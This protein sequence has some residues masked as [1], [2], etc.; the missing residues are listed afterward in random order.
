MKNGETKEKK[1][2]KLMSFW[3]KFLIAL[4][5]TIFA[6]CGVVVG[7]LAGQKEEFSMGGTIKYSVP[8]FTVEF[9][10]YDN[11][12]FNT[13]TVSYGQNATA[14]SSNPSKTGYT[15][16]GW[17]DYT[18]I[19][20]NRQVKSKWTVNIYTITLNNQS[21]TTAGTA[22]VYYKYGTSTFYSNSGCTTTTTSITVPTRTGYTFGGYYSA[23]NGS[24]TQYITAAGAFTSS[25]NSVV[26]VA[27]N[28]TIY[29]KWIP[30]N[31]YLR[32]DWLSVLT[33]TNSNFTAPNI[34]TI[35]FVNTIPSGTGYTTVSVGATSQTGET[36]WTA[37]TSGVLDLTAYVKAN[38]SASSKYDVIFYAPGITYAPLDSSFLFCP[39][40]IDNP[41]TDTFV[42]LTSISFGNFNTTNVTNMSGMFAY[43]AELTNLNLSSFNTSS[44]TNMLGM[45]AFCKELTTLDLSSFDMSEVTTAEM[46]LNCYDPSLEGVM[47]SK[48]RTVKT[49]SS[50]SSALFVDLPELTGYLWADSDNPSTFYTTIS[51]SNTN[52]TLIAVSNEAYLRKDWL[53]VLGSA[54]SQYTGPNIKKIYFER[55]IPTGTGYTTVSVGALNKHGT[56]AFVAGTSGVSDVTAYIK[57]NSSDSTKYDI[58]FY[59]PTTIFAPVNS[60]LLFSDPNTNFTTEFDDGV[61]LDNALSNLSNIYFDN[62]RTTYTTNMSKMFLN[63]IF[64]S[65]PSLATFDTTNVT[66]MSYMFAY[67]I[68]MSNLYFS[69]CANFKTNNVT[70]MAG[71]FLGCS[72]LSINLSTFNTSKVTNMSRMFKQCA[73]LTA[74]SNI[75]NLDTT[76]VTDMSHMF[77]GCTGA[78]GLN[79]STFNTSKV[80]NMSH[81]FSGCDK[82]TSLTL[83]SFSTGSVT[84]MS[85]MFYQ[86]SGLTSLD[87]S[88]FN[89]GNVTDMS[90]MFAMST[91]EGG[92]LNQTL[93]SNIASLNLSN[94]N[95]SKVTNMA[96]M[97]CECINL[98]SLTLSS[99]FVTNNVTDMVS[100]FAR[101]RTLTSLDLSSFDM[102]KCT[103]SYAVNDMFVGCSALTTI[104]TPKAMGSVTVDLPTP[105]NY[106]WFNS[107]LTTTY[108]TLSSSNINKTLLLKRTSYTVRFNANGG[109]VNP[110]SKTV[111]YN[112]TYGTLPTPVREGYTFKGWFT[113]ASGGT[114]ITDSTKFTLTTDQTLYAQWTISESYLQKNWLTTLS[115]AN[116]SY[117]GPN[118]K[119]IQFVNTVPSGSGYATVS[120][121]ATA[122]D[123]GT[124]WTSGSN[125]FDITAYIK[126][127]SS[128]ST[129]Y[130]IIFYSP[131]TIYAP[132][133]SSKLFGN[134][135]SSSTI[136]SQLTSLTFGNFNTSKV[137]NMAYMFY[138]CGL[139]TLD[140]TSFNTSSVNNMYYMFY[141]CT[142]LTSVNVSSFD[143]SNV[144]N[145]SYMFSNVQ[146]TSVNLSSFNTSKVT[147]MSYMFSGCSKLTSLDLSSFSMSLVTNTGNMLYGCSALTTIK[148]PKA[149]G[150]KAVDL[151]TKTAY[152]WK[153]SSGTAYTTISSSNLNTTLTWTA[154]S[155]TV[156]FN[157]N[158]GSCSTTSKQVTYD[159]TY[160]DLPT[161]TRTGYAFKG[162]FTAASGGTQ[163]TASSKVAITAAQTL[164][165][166]W[167]ANTYKVRYFD[168]F[169]NTITYTE[170]T[171]TYD[172]SSKTFP[173][174]SLTSGGWTFVSWAT[175]ATSYAATSNTAGKAVSNLTST[176]GG[177]V[178]LYSVYKRTVTLT[179]AANGGSGSTAAQ[180]EIQYYNRAGKVCNLPSVTLRAN[181]FTRTGYTFTGWQIG[182]TTYAAGA[183]VQ[184]VSDQD[185]PASVTATAQ[186]RANVYKVTLDN[187]SATS[188]GTTA[189]W[190]KFNTVE[191]GYYYYT[192][193]A[194][195]TGLANYTITVPTRTGYTFGGYYTST[196]GGGTQYINASGGCINNMYKS[197]ARN[198][199]L[200]AKWTIN[201][202]TITLNANGSSF[203]S[204][205]TLTLAAS[206]GNWNYNSIS[207]GKFAP[208]TN[209]VITIGSA[210]LTAGT[211]TKFN[212]RLYDF[213]DNK[214]IGTV[215]EGTFGQ[216]NTITITSNSSLNPD[217]DNR[218]I[219]YAG[220]TGSTANNAATFS[221]I[222]IVV[223]KTV[224]YDSTYGTL[225]T[226]TRTGYTFKGWFT[227]ASG[228]TQ[229][230]ASTTLSSAANQ[231]LYAQWTGNTYTIN[232]YNGA[233][234]LG[235]STHTYGSSKALSTWSSLGG[236][237][238]NYSFYGWTTST[239]STSRTYTDGQSVSNL[240]TTAG[241]TITLYAI[242]SGT[243]TLTYSTAR[244]TAPSKQTA[245]RYYNTK[246]GNVTSVSFTLASALSATGF[247]FGGWTISGTTYSAGASYTN[248]ANTISITATAKWNANSY[249]LTL[250]STSVTVSRTSSPYGGAST[251]TLSNG[252]TIYYGDVLKVVT[253]IGYLTIN[254]HN[255]SM[256]MDV[257]I[258]RPTSVGGSNSTLSYTNK[259]TGVTVNSSLTVYGNI[260]VDGSRNQ[261]FRSVWTGN[262]STGWIRNNSQTI[263]HSSFNTQASDMIS[264]SY[265]YRITGKCT[266]GSQSNQSASASFTET[267]YWS[268]DL[269]HASWKGSFSATIGT[270]G[271]SFH[272]SSMGAYYAKGYITEIKVWY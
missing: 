162:W 98:T 97:F 172:N 177:I 190:F 134:Y 234:K 116:S 19:T 166:Q 243:V 219:V 141:N 208:D 178:N 12:V 168:T 204:T 77:S 69:D 209:Y 138:Q 236:S 199:T 231:T 26:S 191:N 8:S 58:T 106:A 59:S 5:I 215:V 155:Y 51:S 195:T 176:N 246:G 192:N 41:L 73:K 270:D 258:S 10:D 90:H 62:F 212:I 169:N 43:C 55:T 154:N 6:T 269:T 254:G 197:E 272:G 29:A 105:D 198:F 249:K 224:T 96:Y 109:T 259:A 113:A 24:G 237:I 130:D 179:Y 265:E 102:S 84:D 117:T 40:E 257:S 50:I 144:A 261:Q 216:S 248:S 104:K 165:A 125:A 52:K 151:P 222:S 135:N 233:T 13:Q 83:S 201:T 7:V 80:T 101:C 45:F 66:D 167:T 239:S 153:N 164:Y 228:G 11:N 211:A 9:L 145:M 227:A 205:T 252:A 32:K 18:N 230:T 38:S 3:S 210:T 142:A 44:V 107:E 173:T 241:G 63:C 225:P 186:W 111:T 35:Q 56:S 21:A 185:S 4:A 251:G 119:T 174:G 202:Y 114:Q 240:T 23:E 238:S 271:V 140:L 149:I 78:T 206:T 187:Q 196:N 33:T 124:A 115:T 121:G 158:G 146:F 39:Q 223:K 34:K 244:G 46:M 213:T 247:S 133:D 30:K 28:Q 75:S 89:T 112:S 221:N 91:S 132:T 137:T 79:L 245:T 263:S 61:D 36:A 31:S 17:E 120:V 181:S 20:A 48:L 264:N 217:H 136:L 214:D 1:I 250:N 207:S 99:S 87:V 25:F 86:C 85:Y 157:A 126:A 47:V 161:A 57:A 156:T 122:I 255:Y 37:S 183:S 65:G 108:T 127:N 128:D 110:A 64:L 266:F 14:P 189:L 42:N 184:L 253:N 171:Y 148:T 226:P 194:C 67:C 159:S 232:Y 182:S 72:N 94:F 170:V 103:G 180:S 93:V 129:K 123:G 260:T 218:I 200:Y 268:G 193:E 22:A 203:L 175:S 143:T 220:L 267:N 70:N 54:N 188:A 71:M 68:S 163:V 100:M 229:V 139:T 27:S 49:P 152:S 160:G 242:G 2:M 82:L 53:T 235:S 131:V 92:L 16:A 95:T 60:S 76:N 256:Y 262:V 81:M 147:N 15:F 74:Y 88:T 118:I 150:S